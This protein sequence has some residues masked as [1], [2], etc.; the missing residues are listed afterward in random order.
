MKLLKKYRTYTYT[1][2][3]FV[4]LIGFLSN[5][6]LFKNSSHMSADEVLH[7]YRN[8]IK[9]YAKE[10]ETL[11]PLMAVNSKIGKITQVCGDVDLSYIN[12]EIVDTLAYDYY[13]DD[14]VIY[15]KM[16]FVV[17]AA[18]GKYIVRL[19]MPTIEED[20]LIGTVVASIL[21]FSLLFILFTTI[22][23]HS[24][25]RH[26]LRPFNNIL[27]MIRT[28]NLDRKSEIHL[29]KSDIDEFVEL[30]RILNRMVG[31]INEGYSEMK[32]FLEYTSH[33][34]QTPLSVIQLKLEVLSQMNSDN[35]EVFGHI[36]SIEN[37]LR[38]AIRFNR[39]IL[40]IAKIR[41]N[42]F[43]DRR[44]M[45]ISRLI[46]H[47]LTQYGEMLS[48]RKISLRCEST[49]DIRMQI[50]PQLAEHLVQN[51]LTNAIKHNYDG[52]SI[53]IKTEV[54][55]MIVSNTFKGSIPEGDLFEKY[56][57]SKEQH[58]SSGLGLAMVKAICQRNNIAAQY[59]IVENEFVMT[60][61]V[62][63]GKGL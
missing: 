14:R 59:K 49:V 47:Y 55:R 28:Y 21:I 2:L 45:N 48:I 33:E 43:S 51:I 37:A 20:M 58:D 1:S 5:Y 39:S 61:E 19:M 16:E 26:I 38:R 29:T 11:V 63:K 40:L 57:H 9:D 52:G 3:F 18:D 23:D 56:N 34:L 31:K 24:F 7:S 6:I 35:P 50:H 36:A 8:D 60:L 10:H 53:Y 17:Q 44:E 62:N 42:Q 22:I 32:E 13:Q 54:N 25:S 15:R 12:D 46:N 30:N 27:E 41:N 4:I